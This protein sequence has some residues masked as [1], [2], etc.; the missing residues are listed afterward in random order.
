MLEP[1]AVTAIVR[2]GQSGWGAKRIAKALG[3][4]RNTVRRYLKAGGAVAYRAPRRRGALAGQETWLRE[5]FLRHRGHCDVVRQLLARERGVAV[6]VRTVERACR[7][8]R[9][10]LEASQRATVRFETAPGEQMPIDFGSVRVMIAGESTRVFLFVATLGYSRRGFVCALRH[11][12]QSAWFSGIEA[13]FA[14]FGGRVRTLLIDNAKAL[15]ESDDLATR[16]VH[17]NARFA[18]FCRHWEVEARACAPFR[19]RTK[20]KTENGVG[21]VKKNAIAGHAFASWA[22]LEGHLARWQ[23]E[24]ADVRR[25]GTT[26]EPPRERFALEQPHLRPLAGLVPFQSVRELVR[27]VNAEACIELDTNAYSV[28][29]RLI[30]ESV[31]VLVSAGQVQIRHGGQ[32]VAAHDELAGRRGRQI[33]RTHRLG[34]GCTPPSEPPSANAL[35]R[36]LAEY[37]ALVGGGW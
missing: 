22:D 26:G 30:G 4:A 33:D 29:W 17:F 14:H 23:R 15:V 31:R 32:E 11:E 7:G 5:P 27:R 10:E 12:R 16:Q 18:A 3:M 21:Y 34:A 25:H 20:G 13:A 6:H 19:A 28:P 37:D 2:L 8:Y 1:E 35:L 36:P 24:V 9:Q